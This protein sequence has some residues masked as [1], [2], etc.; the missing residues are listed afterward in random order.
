MLQMNYYIGIDIGTT[1]TKAVAF[2]VNGEVLAKEAIGYAIQHPQ[3][4]CSEQDPDEIFEAV[5]NSISKITTTLYNHTPVLVSFSAAMHSI[6]AVD[7]TG[8]PL[9]PCII[10]ADNR[11][12][13]IAEQLRK[14][15]LG[16]DFYHATGVPV[17][18][19]SPLCKLLWMKENNEPVFRQ[20]HKFIGIK[21][22]IFFR[23]FGKYLVDTAI[24]SATGLLND[25]ENFVP[26]R[27]RRK[28][29]T[30]T[31]TLLVLSSTLR[32]S[33]ATSRHGKYSTNMYGL[34]TTSVR[35]LTLKSVG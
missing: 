19:M 10:W 35:L 26:E 31:S 30:R 8:K 17:H 14:S 18:A 11:A 9:T 12:G 4:D 16:N 7:R 28:R 13:D 27:S 33:S 22:Y 25:G 1:S 15:S 34:I 2:S 6:L 29:Y 23:L 3:P 21:E 24:A 5:I 20:A 32:L